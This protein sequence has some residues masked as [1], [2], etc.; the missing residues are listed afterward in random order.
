MVCFHAGLVCLELR[1]LIHW[2]SKR[3]SCV[4]VELYQENGKAAEISWM[5]PHQRAC[6]FLEIHPNKTE[7]WRHLGSK[8]LSAKYS[9]SDTIP[10][11][12]SLYVGH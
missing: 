3:R 4:H 7:E 11:W 8:D 5:V 10:L 12:F 1:I 6:S 9:V 2:K